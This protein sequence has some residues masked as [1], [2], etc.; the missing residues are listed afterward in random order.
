MGEK[1]TILELGYAVYL[2]DL[3]D[4][5]WLQENGDSIPEDPSENRA[6]RKSGHGILITVDPILVALAIESRWLRNGLPQP[7]GI[8]FPVPT[9]YEAVEIVRNRKILNDFNNKWAGFVP[10]LEL[11]TNRRRIMNCQ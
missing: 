1:Y 10:G 3:E 9:F 2:M 5:N 11:I 6:E 7:Q 8:S 4:E